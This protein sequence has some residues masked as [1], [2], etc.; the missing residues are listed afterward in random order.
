MVGEKGVMYSPSDYGTEYKLLPEKNFEGFQ[1]PPEKL[2]RNGG[3]DEGM[4]REWIEAA[5]A[6][7]PEMAL[8][9]FNYSAVLTEAILL[10][11]VAIRMNGQK[12]EW[13]GPN[14]KITNN[15]DANK[16]IKREYRQGWE[17]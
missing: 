12:L 9:N 14:L 16:W 1:G 6:G 10:G 5:K 15:A 4:K 7:K 17:L 2:P 13:D 11:N 8:S 3:G